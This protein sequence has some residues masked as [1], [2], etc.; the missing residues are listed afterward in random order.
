MLTTYVPNQ[1]LSK[2]NPIFWIVCRALSLANLVIVSCLSAFS[3]LL[4]GFLTNSVHA[5]CREH[6][7]HPLLACASSRYVVVDCRGK[8]RLLL[9]T[10]MIVYTCCLLSTYVV[11]FLFKHQM[12]TQGSRMF[13]TQFT[14]EHQTSAREQRSHRCQPSYSAI[15]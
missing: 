6:D 12:S 9:I 14:G 1:N 7:E 13:Q 11:L 4:K 8:P 2:A 3:L 5:V 15:S 10:M